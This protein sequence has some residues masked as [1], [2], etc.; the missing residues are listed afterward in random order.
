M[1][2]AASP[3][4]LDPGHD[5]PRGPRQ[6]WGW[7]YEFAGLEHQGQGAGALT[8]HRRPTWLRRSLGASDQQRTYYRSGGHW[9]DE[10]GG[11][12]TGPVLQVLE[13]LWSGYRPDVSTASEGFPDRVQ[14]ASEDSFPA[15]DAPA[16]T[17]TCV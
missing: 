15:S 8:V 17:C 13:N 3:S 10:K 16:W 11:K 4:R 9:R 14:I 6:A 12:V 2:A 7:F 5:A 1:M